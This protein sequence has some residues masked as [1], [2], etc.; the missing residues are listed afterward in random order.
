MLKSV[1]VLTLCVVCFALA[2]CGGGGGGTA[3]SVPESRTGK[4]VDGPVEGLTYESGSQKGVTDA[5]GTFRYEEGKAVKFSVGGILIGQATA[6][7]VMTPITLA[8]ESNPSADATTDQVVA[9]VRFLMAVSEIDAAGNMK[10][11]ASARS[12]TLSQQIDF[13]AVSDQT[14]G[15][16]VAQLGSTMS[17]TAITAQ[18]ATDHLT[19]SL[20]SINDTV[21]P[22]APANLATSSVTDKSVNL[23][24]TASTDNI[25]VTNYWVYRDGEKIG[26]TQGT[27]FSDTTVTAGSS[28]SYLVRALDAAGNVSQASAAITVA[29]PAVQPAGD[30]TAPSAPGNLKV[31]TFDDRRDVSLAWD[32]ATDNVGVSGYSVYRN[33]I[34]IGQSATVTTFVDTTTEPATTY[35]YQVEA[36]DAAGNRSAQ[37]SGVT[38][39]TFGV[40][41]IAGGQLQ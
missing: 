30:K 17:I 20:A 26:Q 3:S 6:Q 8:R 7:P 36:F 40:T 2:A 13:A 41:I 4:F 28:F 39:K 15:T 23:T 19:G 32:A 21:P 14:L 9:R 31:T 1:K 16:L 29:T 33:G 27:A 34:L 12:A 10:I 35:T 25:A 18:T 24:W 37:N 11:I 38:I 5:S 22:S